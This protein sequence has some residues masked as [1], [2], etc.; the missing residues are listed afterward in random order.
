MRRLAGMHY[1]LI[2]LEK[3]IFNTAMLG[4]SFSTF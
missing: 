2:Y 3:C 4:L 1:D